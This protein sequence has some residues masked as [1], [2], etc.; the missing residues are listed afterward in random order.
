MLGNGD[1]VFR[2]KFLLFFELALYG[3]RE[4]KIVRN[5]DETQL[6]VFKTLPLEEI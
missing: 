5:V 4:R 1:P 3:K 2:V 6:S